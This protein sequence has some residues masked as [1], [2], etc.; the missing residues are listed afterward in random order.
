MRSLRIETAPVFEPLLA[1]EVDGHPVRYRGA[2]GGRGSAKSWF[3]ADL[4]LERC[5]RFQPTRALCV[6]EIQRTLEQ[7]VKRLL[8]D[9]IRRLD[10]GAYFHSMDNRIETPG[11]GVIT[12]EGMQAHN[13]S[14]IKSLEGY[15]VAWVEEAQALSDRSLTLLRPTIRTPGSEL[16]FSWNPSQPTDPVDVLLRGTY[17]PPDALVVKANY[18][19]NPW[20]PEVLRLEMEWDR[21]RDA[22]KY[23]HIWLGE[24]EQM[25][26]ARVFKN[27]RVEEFAEP[28]NQT[29]FYFGAD[30]GFAVDPTV[31]V[32]CWIDGRTLYVDREVYRVGCEIEDTPALFDQL[33]GGQARKWLI[34]A[35]SARPETISYMRRHGYPRMVSAKKGKGSVEEGIAFLQSYD[36]VVHPRCQHAIDELTL[37]HYKTDPLTGAVLPILKDEKNHVIDAMRYAIEAARK[38]IVREVKLPDGLTRASDWS[39]PGFVDKPKQDDELQIPIPRGR[40]RSQWSY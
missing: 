34:T 10:L 18:Q 33:E 40:H 29:V 1:D 36:I 30:W 11:G 26:E 37:Y 31:L 20:F 39:P 19:D 9:E 35:D 25:S 27:W 3:F 15:T 22:E 16:W 21:A 23:A 8:D 17:L 12:F 4:L 28:S 13:A 14:S 32:R 2:W 24:Y 38:G 5:L 7:S 6:R